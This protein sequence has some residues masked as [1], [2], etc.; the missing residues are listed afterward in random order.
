M[1]TRTGRQRSANWGM[2]KFVVVLR[3][4]PGTTHAQFR[5]YFDDIHAPL[6]R[7]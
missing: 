3:R 2:V 5:R 7:Q 6:A 4:K 1:T